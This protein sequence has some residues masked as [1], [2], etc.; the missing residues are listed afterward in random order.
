M[1]S[2][3]ITRYKEKWDTC[4]DLFDSIALQ[5]GI[6][7]K[8]IEVIVANDGTEDL[9]D[10]NLFKNYPFTVNYINHEHAGVSATRNFALDNS[11]GDYVMFCD[12]DDMFIN[13]LGLHLIFDAMNDVPDVIHSSFIEE[14]LKEDEYKIIRHD[15]DVTF[16]HGKAYRRGY[17]KNESLRFKEDLTIHEDGY[18]NLL[19]S[20]C[21]S[22]IK[23]IST[24]FYMWKFN[25][26]STVRRDP[27]N[28]VM[29]TYD[30]LMKCREAIC[31]E[32]E[33]RG[34]IDQYID[35]VCKTVIDS[36][37]DFNK[38]NYLIP[39]NKE[40]VEKAEKAFKKFYDKFGTEYK[41][42][43]ITR[44][45]EIMFISRQTAYCNGMRVEQRT[46]R[47]WLNHITK[48]V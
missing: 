7:F 11:K 14:Q 29:K 22:S 1:L 2:I 10:A 20:V 34:Y 13:S 21:T 27:E 5:R 31:E 15:K 26:E 4:K 38:A 24:P 33:A 46:I 6:N 3:C 43:N 32:L 19:A 35:A 18:F 16:I 28:Y 25:T 39:K 12:I 30:H 36:Y 37:Y 17:L 41:E 40:D 45:G 48:E 8:D 9:L 42:A 23:H 47:E 44:I